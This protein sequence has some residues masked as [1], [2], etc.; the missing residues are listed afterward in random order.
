[1]PLHNNF[2]QLGNLEIIETYEYYDKPLLFAC[3]NTIGHIFLAVIIDET[4]VEE[5]WLYAPISE[6]RFNEIR[7]GK[8]DLHD[9]FSRAEDNQLYRVCIPYDQDVQ[10]K[11]L[12]INA[13]EVSDNDLPLKGEKLNL[14]TQTLP[15]A[16]SLKQ[17]KI[18]AVQT[19]REQIALHLDLNNIR[20]TEAPAEL[21]GGV[22]QRFQQLLAS[23][24]RSRYRPGKAPKDAIP[25]VNVRRF[26]YASFT[27]ELV[28]DDIVDL[29]KI[30]KT[31]DA[32]E[33][34][35]ELINIHNNLEG[36][37]EKIKELRPNITFSYAQF[38]KSLDIESLISDTHIEWASPRQH[39]Q[40]KTA[41]INAKQ[42]KDTIDI[43]EKAELKPPE[44]LKVT[45]ILIGANLRGKT[46]ELSADERRKKYAGRISDKYLK[47]IRVVALGEHYNATII[48][49]LI[50]NYATEK[51]EY[52]YELI[53]LER[54]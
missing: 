37:K 17:M 51:P 4:E 26:S 43:I 41:S 1:M 25:Q 29:L 20:Q 31:G 15:E 18:Q 46:F 48:Q 19:Q 32:L 30:S 7:A 13:S 42:V 54:I 47:N 40:L 36:I 23:V 27:V 24:S 28:S 50:I 52:K 2:T 11:L 14:Y 3:Q 5:V 6:R 33:Q 35:I 44:V 8:M 45:G 53:N 22:L 10:A 39:G 49:T 9:A 34:I 38:L 16:P 12:Y 21:L